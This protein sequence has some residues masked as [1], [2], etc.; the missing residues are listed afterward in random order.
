MTEIERSGNDDDEAKRS[1]VNNAIYTTSIEVS[2][3]N[4]LKFDTFI[5]LFAQTFFL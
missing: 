2:K 3:Q 5:E 4:F 1:D